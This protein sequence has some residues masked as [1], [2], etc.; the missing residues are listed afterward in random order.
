MRKYSV[1]VIPLAL[2]IAGIFQFAC[3]GGSDVTT[4]QVSYDA[5]YPPRGLDWVAGNKRITFSWDSVPFAVGYFVYL[6]NDGVDFRLYSGTQP[7]TQTEIIITHVINDQDYYVGVSAVGS[8]GVET[9]ISYPG[10]APNAMPIT[11]EEP[12]PDFPDF[13]GIPPEPPANLQG[14]AGDRLIHLEWDH[15]TE[16]DFDYYLVYRR[17]GDAGLYSNFL[18]TM[19]NVWDDNDVKNGNTYY[20]F[21]TATDIE[22]LE[23]DPSNIVKYT[24]QSAPPLAP[25]DFTAKWIALDGVVRLNW[26]EPFSEPDVVAYRIVRLDWT[27]GNIDSPEESLVVTAQYPEDPVVGFIPPIDDSVFLTRGHKYQYEILAIDQENQ[28]GPP[29]L[30]EM[31]EIPTE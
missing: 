3:T 10:G 28:W 14:F 23:S 5:S 17:L 18:P 6:S 8:S 25:Q 15:N 29:V 30:S 11:P 27:D 7:I 9:A 26:K 4:P 13:A 21:V 20:Y 2:L 24:P 1:F 12:V 31:V 19:N 16:P 22:E